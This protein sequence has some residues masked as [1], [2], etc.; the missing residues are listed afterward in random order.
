MVT[1]VNASWL[2]HAWQ[3]AN[4]NNDDARARDYIADV[5]IYCEDLLKF[6]LRGEG[7]AIPNLSLDGLKQEL[8]RLYEAHVPPFD[9]KAGS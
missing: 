9:R 5:R 8:K 6:M 2:Q 1:I 3:E 7:P 4:D